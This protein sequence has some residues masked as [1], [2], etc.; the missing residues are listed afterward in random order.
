MART[1][2][3]WML[4]VVVVL[5]VVVTVVV[6]LW[7]R[8]HGGGPTQDEEAVL[9]QAAIDAIIPPPDAQMRSLVEQDAGPAVVFVD[10]LRALYAALPAEVRQ[11]VS[12]K[13]EWV[14]HLAD[15][16][17]AQADVIRELADQDENWRRNLESHFGTPLDLSKV[18]FLFQRQGQYVALRVRGPGFE[19]NW[20]P[21]G[22]LKSE[23]GQ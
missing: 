11:Q 4:W 20:A 5:V 13:G 18:T 6:V 15:L 10:R 7:V 1:S 9:D 19:S 23:P 14:F 3:R 2:G 16:P 12:S 22:M 17:K 21:F 8:T